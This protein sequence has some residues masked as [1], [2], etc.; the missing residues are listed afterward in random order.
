MIATLIE[1][2]RFR[3][4]QQVSFVGGEGTI[5]NFKSESGNWTYFI[6]MPLEKE[7]DFGRVG[8]ET[9]VVLNEAELQTV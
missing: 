1:A 9:I 5:R 2:P 8:A 7:P 6:E 4:A 3:H